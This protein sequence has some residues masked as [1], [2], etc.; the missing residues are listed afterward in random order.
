[1]MSILKINSILYYS[2]QT[3]ESNKCYIKWY[4]DALHSSKKN[5]LDSMHRLWTFGVVWLYNVSQSFHL[6]TN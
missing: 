4:K 6:F 2:D 5:Y 1:M 3:Q